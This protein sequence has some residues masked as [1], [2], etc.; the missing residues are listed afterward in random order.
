M[1]ILILFLG[2][3]SFTAPQI[4]IENAWMRLANKGMNTALYVDVTNLSSK[5]DELVDASSNI[6]NT[7]QIHET[8]KQGD[9]MGMRRIPSVTIKGKG[10]FHFAPG[11]FHIMVIKLKENLKEGEKKEFTLTF[12]HAGKVK[13]RAIVKR[14]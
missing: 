12:K 5:E 4:K 9:N 13:I 7:V 1:N 2:L 10:T 14:D 6:A 3:F 11:G 8:Y